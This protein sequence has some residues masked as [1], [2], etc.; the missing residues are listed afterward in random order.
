MTERDSP[1]EDGGAAGNGGRE[2]P[3]S[4]MNLGQQDR[5]DRATRGSPVGTPRPGAENYRTKD[6]HAL[7]TGAARAS[8]AE[9]RDAGVLHPNETTAQRG[10]VMD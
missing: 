4:R 5:H 9:G 10:R 2:S 1:D 3:P 6:Q 8:D 7:T